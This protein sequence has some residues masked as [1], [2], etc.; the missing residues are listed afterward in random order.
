I[1]VLLLLTLFISVSTTVN[2]QK[3]K[4]DEEP[5]IQLPT[6]NKNESDKVYYSEVVQTSGSTADIYKR[7]VKWFNTY[8]KSPSS[9]IKETKENEMIRGAGRMRLMGKATES[10]AR[11]G[12]AM[13]LYDVVI[14]AKEGRYKYELKNFR[15]KG[16]TSTDIE[17]I[18]SDTEA[19]YDRANADYLV[20]VEENQ[21]KI[22]Q[23]IKKTMEPQGAVK[24]EA[25]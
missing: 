3:R 21:R 13:M 16:K 17:K 15:M 24:K 2:G 22:I 10:G 20:Q 1:S 19:N 5:I 18:I 9:I 14:Y 4:K 6:F 12:T 25:W 7:A 11:A 23:N 8:Y